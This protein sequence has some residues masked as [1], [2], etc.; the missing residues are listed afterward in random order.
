MV[1]PF[2]LWK[3]KIQNLILFLF[4]LINRSKAGQYFSYDCPV[5]ST[6]ENK[7]HCSSNGYCYIDILQYYNR[8]NPQLLSSCICNSGWMTIDNSP[9]KCCYQ[10]KNQMKAFMLEF[11]G[12]GFGHF[13]VGN[14]IRGMIK[15]CGSVFLCVIFCLSG[16]LSCYR[17]GNYEF[18][19]SRKRNGKFYS[20]FIYG[21][22]IFYL[23][24][25]LIDSVLFG[26]NF[27]TDG[28]GHPLESW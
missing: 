20:I 2:Q 14:Y 4:I 28:E 26:I 23:V 18:R 13:Y 27:Y 24:W 15:L 12:F 1:I 17:E 7:D 9:V 22:L 21:S 6:C 8:S 10:M 3:N 5:T 25:M 19:A 11:I 16:F